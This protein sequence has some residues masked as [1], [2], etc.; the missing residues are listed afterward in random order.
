M[1]EPLDRGNFD[2]ARDALRAAG[3]EIGDLLLISVSNHGWVPET[4][5]LTV[6]QLLS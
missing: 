3:I 6:L 1:A 4:L 2:T 5:W